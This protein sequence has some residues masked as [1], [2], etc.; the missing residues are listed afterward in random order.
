[1]S[2]TKIMENKIMKSLK[3]MFSGLLF[4]IVTACNTTPVDMS[5]YEFDDIPTVDSITNWTL[6][7]WNA[8]DNRSLI[9]QTS[10][11]DYYLFILSVPNPDLRFALTV[12]ITST[13]GQVQA[14]FD[15]VS[16]PNDLMLRSPIEKIYKLA[17]KDQVNE[18]TSK[19]QGG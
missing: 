19:I 8:I 6:D 2:K 11:R 4:I 15:T 18:V 9:V 1:M 5:K 13:A 7:G 3:L 14:R 10:P 17:D 16:T 12:A